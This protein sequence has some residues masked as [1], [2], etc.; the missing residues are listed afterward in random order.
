MQQPTVEP[1]A[2]PVE[3]ERNEQ[4]DD[5]C[6]VVGPNGL[7]RCGKIPRP[8]PGSRGAHKR[9]ECEAAGHMVCVVCIDEWERSAGR[10]W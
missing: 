8:G 3:E 5:L 7:T 10:R 4:R 1:V 9:R 6:H 2:K